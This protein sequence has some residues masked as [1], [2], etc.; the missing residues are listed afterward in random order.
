MIWWVTQSRRATDERLGIA[1][2]EQRTAWLANVRWRL[3]ND[4]ILAADFEIILPDSEVVRLTIQYPSFFP[5]VPP[6]VLS[7][8][9][10]RI[11]GHQ[12]GAGGELCLEFRPDNWEPSVTG[13]MMIQ[14]AY[15]LITGER[16]ASAEG[17][18]RTEVP[19]AHEVTFGQ[20]IRASSCRLILTS[21]ASTALAGVQV[22]EPV[23]ARFL[24][25][26]YAKTWT[27]YVTKVGDAWSENP[28]VEGGWK[29]E[30]T[31]V[32]LPAGATI[33][34]PFSLAT[35][36]A[37]FDISGLSECLAKLQKEDEASNW[38]IADDHTC[39][40]L[41]VY[42][43]DEDK[44]QAIAY[45]T[46]PL[47]TDPAIR[48]PA[49]NSALEGKRVG[50]VG[51]GSVGSKVAVSLARS[52]IR[53]FTLIDGDILL[54]GNLVRNEL[55]WRA[56]GVHKVEAVS[57]RILEVAPN[58]DVSAFDIELGGQES[59]EKTT[60]VMSALSSCDLIVE[61]TADPGAFN[62]C[63][64]VAR[65]HE[66]PIVW[67]E[68]FAGG[69]GGIIARSRPQIEPPP[70]AAR[71][72]INAWCD[73]HG[74][75]PGFA[76]TEMPYTALNPERRPM[77]ADDSDVSAVAASLARLAVDTIARPESSLFPQSAYAIGLS[78][79][80]IF[81][82]PFDT[83]PIDLAYEDQWGGPSEEFDEQRLMSL[84]ADL[85]PRDENNADR[86]PA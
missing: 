61:A 35:I 37:L 72:Q 82:A 30:A 54:P 14:S 20:E 78:A 27:A 71:R 85:F 44:R 80:W 43:R 45:R 79:G 62:L 13:A 34:V 32:R 36:T 9:H 49:E 50:I 31:A 81:T 33:P 64:A 40:L 46:I 3:A 7:R 48:L 19:S 83:W 10:H 84:L 5:D 70:Q 39:R 57:A 53:N 17:N 12:Y 11:S 4:F 22:L 59:A 60:L 67:A 21:G 42:A 38:L 66:K 55:D 51:C 73:N 2:L 47:S 75:M 76:A 6:L 63:A 8:D 65:T 68:V 25:K 1:D 52:G 26:R 28:P 18:E 15:R 58:A 41:M 29:Y 77:T 16:A 56:V 23:P 74:K 69:I 24:E 86:P